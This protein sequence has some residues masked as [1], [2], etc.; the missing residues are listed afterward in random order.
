MHYLS[1]SF[2]NSNKCFTCRN[3]HKL[4][5]VEVIIFFLFWDILALNIIEH[6]LYKI[7]IN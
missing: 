4:K 1:F 2:F 6:A 3:D 5:P 7:N